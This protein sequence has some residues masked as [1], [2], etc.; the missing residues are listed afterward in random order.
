MRTLTEADIK[1]LIHE[2]DLIKRPW[3]VICHPDMEEQLKKIVRDD[4]VVMSDSCVPVGK[5]YVGNRRE[6]EDWYLK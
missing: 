3:V 4:M 5:I 6:F 2:F 1:R